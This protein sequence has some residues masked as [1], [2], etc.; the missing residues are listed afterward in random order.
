MSEDFVWRSLGVEIEHLATRRD[1]AQYHDGFQRP[2]IGVRGKARN[3]VRIPYG[4]NLDDC[5]R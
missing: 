3:L 2:P 1:R 4:H 5:D